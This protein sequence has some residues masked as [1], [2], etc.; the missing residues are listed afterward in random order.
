MSIELEVQQRDD[1]GAD[2]EEPEEAEER[3]AEAEVLALELSVTHRITG[4]RAA[5]TKSSAR[6]A[7][8]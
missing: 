6:Y 8:E 4:S 2:E 7:S 3:P 1:R 5:A